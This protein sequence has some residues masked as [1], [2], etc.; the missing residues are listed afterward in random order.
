MDKFMEIYHK[1]PKQSKV[2][3]IQNA[4]DNYEDKWFI[5]K[6]RT[7]LVE[8]GFNV[9]DVD[10]RN[11]NEDQLRDELKDVDIVFVC[12]GNTFYLL[13]KIQQS[14]F[15]KVLKDLLNKGVYYIGS[16]AGSLITGLNIELVKG[17][18]DPN[19]A[20]SLKSYDGLGFVDFVMIVHYKP[21]R[22]ELLKEWS[23]KYKVI[24]LTDEQAIVVDGGEYKVI[25]K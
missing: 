3:F 6:D 1:D 5:E 9:I 10:L 4:A 23:K 8:L 13:E 7:K 21:E 11:K 14:G 19:E 25:G 24:T 17:F 12:G 2:G 15:D 16:S 18:D 20:P 22:D